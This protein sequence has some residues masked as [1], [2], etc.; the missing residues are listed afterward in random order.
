MI[1]ILGLSVDLSV[2]VECLSR[3]LKMLYCRIL[4]HAV[5]STLNYIWHDV[6]V[7]KP[8]ALLLEN[9]Q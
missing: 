8:H 4:T 2:D 6:Y 7:L 5:R 1:L 3:I 9:T